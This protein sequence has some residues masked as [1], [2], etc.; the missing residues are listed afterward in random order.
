MPSR[1]TDG[2][3]LKASP[4]AK[5]FFEGLDG[6]NRYAVLWRIA[7]AKTP[8]KKTAKIAEMMAKLERGE[9]LH[10]KR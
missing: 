9:R 6:A 5:A 8:E 3:A 2:A 4:K 7:Q 1:V 10:E